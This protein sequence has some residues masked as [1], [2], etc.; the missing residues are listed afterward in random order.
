M[1]GMAWQAAEC[2]KPKT[3]RRRQMIMPLRQPLRPQFDLFLSSVRMP[4]RWW[5]WWRWSSLLWS[6]GS[7]SNSSRSQVMVSEQS[8]YVCVCL[9]AIDSICLLHILVYLL[10]CMLRLLYAY[11]T[12]VSAASN[13]KDSLLLL[14][15]LLMLLLL[16]CYWEVEEEN[17]ISA[18]VSI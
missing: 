9:V 17:A 5:W 3:S 4:G 13:T 11:I 1:I 16:Y 15:L 12:S 18:A 7:S 6:I 10:T 2:V 8:T 14:L